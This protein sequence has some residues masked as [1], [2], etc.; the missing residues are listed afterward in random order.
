ML[1][2]YAHV[3]IGFLLFSCLILGMPRY[4]YAHNLSSLDWLAIH[5]KYVNY[6]GEVEVVN[7]G[8]AELLRQDFSD[9]ISHITGISRNEL[10]SIF[11]GNVDWNK[12]AACYREILSEK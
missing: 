8:V 3:F 4:V 2:K 6:I 11:S 12:V 7:D 9:K 10:N 5:E 1:R